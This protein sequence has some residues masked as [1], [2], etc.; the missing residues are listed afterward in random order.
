MTEAEFDKSLEYYK[1]K[2]DFNPDNLRDDIRLRPLAKELGYTITYGKTFAD[3][4]TFTKEDVHIWGCIHDDKPMWAC[5]QLNS[6]KRYTN[7]RYYDELELA[8]RKETVN[9]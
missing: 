2:K 6:E 7:H 5:A 4:L 9:A 8:L 1:T 3:S